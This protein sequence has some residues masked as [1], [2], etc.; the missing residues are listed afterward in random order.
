MFR[1]LHLIIVLITLLTTTLHAQTNP[2]AD[3]AYVRDN[4]DKQ[5]VMV[6]MRDGIK[7]FTSIY[8]PK[9]KSKKY[10]IIMRR[11]PYSCAPYG[12]TAYTKSFQNMF[13]ARTGYIF[14]VQDVRGKY[15]SE[16]EFVDVRPFNPNKQGNDIDEATD[17]YDA[18]EWLIKNLPTN[19]GRIGTWG[20]S[21]PGFYAT[22]TILA[23][24]PAIKAVSPQA[25]VTDWFLGD[26]FHHNGAFFMMDAFAFYSG[27]GKPRPKPTTA[28]SMPFR[29][30]NTP[31]N[32]NFYLS[33]GALRNFNEKYLKNEIPFWNEVMQHPNYDA[34]WQARNPRPYLKNITPAVL[35]VGGHFDAEDCYGAWRVYGAIEKQNAQTASNRIVMGPWCHGCWARQDGSKLGN[36]A[37][38]SNTSLYYQENIEFKFFEYYLKDKGTMDLPD[39]SIFETGSNRWTTYDTWPPKNAQ[40]VKYFFHNNGQLSTTPPAETSKKTAVDTYIS[41]PA[42]PV[43]YTEDIHLR[44]TREYMLDDQRFASRRPDVLTYQIG[45][46]TE[47]LT[48]T[49]TLIADLWVSTTGTDADFVVKLI[50]VLPDTLRAVSNGVPLGGYQMLVRGEVMRGR[51]RNSFEKPEAFKSGK[52]TQVRF[53]LPDV[54]HTFL[55]GHRLMVQVQSSWFP[56]V[57]RNPQQF[58]NIYEAKDSDFIKA[59]HKIYRTTQYPSGIILPVKR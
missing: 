59:T 4:Y 21:Y 11:T 10:P 45:P 8:T 47:P 58:V 31:D 14:V 38:G 39:A 34:F 37:F 23:N 53:E 57:D 46:L 26:D 15:M 52:V 48:V 40:S 24:H 27:F 22:M 30:W 12:A 50:D 13:L 9:D 49:G 3:S 41:D 55:P 54:A 16:G 18:A 2:A 25:P 51:F 56:L 44:R 29:D 36:I 5:E 1:N 32:Y 20:I 28:F 7:L 33:T 19:N 42:K 35:T 43:P 17:T 6:P